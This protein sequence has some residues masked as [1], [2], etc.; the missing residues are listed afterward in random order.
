MKTVPDRRPE[1]KNVE[2]Y[3]LCYILI[4]TLLPENSN[5]IC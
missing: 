5:W 4:L 1:R 3:R 2:L